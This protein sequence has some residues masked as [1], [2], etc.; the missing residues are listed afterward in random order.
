MLERQQYFISENVCSDDAPLP[1]SMGTIPPPTTPTNSMPI[2]LYTNRNVIEPGSHSDK[3]P[4]KGELLAIQAKSMIRMARILETSS[5]K[6]DNLLE[7][8][9]VAAEINNLRVAMELG[10]DDTKAQVKMLLSL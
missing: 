8:R 6:R 5:L 2:S 1:I 3:P 7:A 10:E 4:T 9:I